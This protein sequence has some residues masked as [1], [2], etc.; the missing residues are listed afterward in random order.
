M[1][2][3]TLLLLLLL[4]LLFATSTDPPPTIYLFLPFFSHLFHVLFFPSPLIFFTTFSHRPAFPLHC[5]YSTS[6]IPSLAHTY[7]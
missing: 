3:P 1:D 2:T 5:T 4:L 6:P 7:T